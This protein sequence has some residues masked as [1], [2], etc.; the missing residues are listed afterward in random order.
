MKAVFRFFAS[1]SMLSHLFVIITLIMGA[2]AYFGINRTLLPMI[3]TGEVGVYTYLPG[4]GP[5]DVEL[6][7]TNRIEDELK[8]VPNVQRIT[9]TSVEGRSSVL[10]K[11]SPTSKTS[12]RVSR[13]SATPSVESPT[14]PQRSRSG[15]GLPS[16]R[17]P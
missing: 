11:L 15:Q 7:I 5:E 13:R 1:R 10:I 4:A 17:P 6:N 2:H 9:S 16:L 14:F 3:S 8:A 12:T